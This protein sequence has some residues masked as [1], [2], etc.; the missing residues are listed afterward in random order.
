LPDGNTILLTEYEVVALVNHLL[1]SQV[2]V[3]SENP[4]P[5]A[6]GN[7]QTLAFR[8]PGMV[9]I[10]ES[11]Q[12]QNGEMLWS[13][14]YFKRQQPIVPEGMHPMQKIHTLRGSCANDRCWPESFRN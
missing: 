13:P 11:G 6:P 3:W 5:T 9:S 12:A 2:A 10:T 8:Q 4:S 1:E 7:Y 14:E